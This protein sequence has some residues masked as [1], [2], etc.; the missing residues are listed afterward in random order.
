MVALQPSSFYGANLCDI[1]AKLMANIFRAA[2]AGNV[3]TP[4][5]AARFLKQISVIYCRAGSK[6]H[7][8]VDIDLICLSSNR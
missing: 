8:P 6:A 7:R 5:S 4:S 1:L 3:L 2:T